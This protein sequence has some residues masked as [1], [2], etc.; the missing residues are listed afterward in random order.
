MAAVTVLMVAEKPS[1]ALSIAGQLSGGKVRRFRKNVKMQEK[2]HARHERWALSMNIMEACQADQHPHHYFPVESL[3]W[4][5][6]QIC[7]MCSEFGL[8][9]AD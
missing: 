8:Q 4:M 7:V 9:L 5:I 3:P 6:E 2:M 1:L